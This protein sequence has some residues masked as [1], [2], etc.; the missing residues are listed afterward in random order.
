MSVVSTL[1]APVIQMGLV[2]K[3]VD[4]EQNRPAVQQA[5]AQATVR[6][7]L[8]EAQSRVP[9]PGAP[10]NSR[11]VQERG[12]GRDSPGHSRD[13]RPPD[14]SKAANKERTGSGDLETKP[15]SGHI[16]NLKI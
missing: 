10:E 1:P 4:L 12:S 8:R 14:D 11:K 6:H 9:D 5:L 16:V 15:W 13:K 7:E 3:K 2:E